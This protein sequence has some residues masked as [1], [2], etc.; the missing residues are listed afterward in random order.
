MPINPIT[1]K[2]HMGKYTRL[3]KRSKRLVDEL[4]KF[5]AMSFWDSR[6]GNG[7]RVVLEAIDKVVDV[8]RERVPYAHDDCVGLG[9]EGEGLA[10]VDGVVGC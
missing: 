5:I 6:R 7:R 3:N 1:S 9:V 4:E 10:A 8:V 2:L